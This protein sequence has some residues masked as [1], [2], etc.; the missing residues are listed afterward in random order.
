MHSDW[1]DNHNKL[2]R[3][4]VYKGYFYE[5]LT[6]ASQKSSNYTAV[7]VITFRSNSTYK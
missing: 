7:T 4:N 2:Y 6:T 3:S 1:L 5:F